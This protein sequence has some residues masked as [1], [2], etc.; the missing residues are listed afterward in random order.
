M[1]SYFCGWYYRCQS[2]QHTLAAIPSLHRTPESN[3]CMIQLIT[4]TD[5]F[6]AVFPYSAFQKDGPRIRIA[7][8][9]FGPSGI[10]LNLCQA[11]FR[12]AGDL[13]F[14][15]FAPLRYDIMGPFQYLP[16]MQCRHSISSMRHTVDGTLTVNGMAY[17]FQHGAG[18]LEGDR[19]RSFPKKY[20]WTCSNVPNGTVMLSVAEI[21]LGL[22][23]FTGVIGVV[24]LNGKEYRLA[25]Y[26]GARAVSIQPQEIV[27][28]QGSLCLTV[29]RHPVLGHPLRAPVC[30]FMRRTIHEHPSCVVF[31]HFEDQE[32]VLLDYHAPNA[33]FEYEY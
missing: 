27:I 26:L 11:G 25:S 13:R 12:A 9:C 23:R 14:G 15:P 29:R 17:V 28:R 3:F 32:Q 4:D 8:N 2:D 31:Y 30:G 33:S 10:H 6:Q 18:Y 19:G 22:V 16:L 21:P 7:K 24:L 1:G 20:L 5:A